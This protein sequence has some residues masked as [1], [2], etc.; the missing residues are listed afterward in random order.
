LLT[1]VHLPT[2]RVHAFLIDNLPAP[3]RVIL[4]YRDHSLSH[5]DA[6]G[7]AVLQ[8]QFPEVA[9]LTGVTVAAGSKAPFAVWEL[10]SLPLLEG[11]LGD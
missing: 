11:F 4:P 3:Q 6:G 5:W 8:H 7:L 2:G 10:E 9:V 1:V